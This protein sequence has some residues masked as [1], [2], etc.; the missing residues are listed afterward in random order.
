MGLADIQ[1]CLSLSEGT[2]LATK[3]REKDL[4]IL[5]S[6]RSWQT[7]LGGCQML[8]F[9]IVQSIYFIFVRVILEFNTVV[10]EALVKDVGNLSQDWS[11]MVGTGKR[12]CVCLCE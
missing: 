10:E 6:L 5:Q 9:N 3:R 7:Y 8:P 4:A 11:M 12:F 2:I 1:M